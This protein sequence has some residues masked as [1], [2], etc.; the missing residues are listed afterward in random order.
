MISWVSLSASEASPP[1]VEVWHTAT[2]ETP[3]ANYAYAYD[4]SSG[5]A[6]YAGVIAVFI[7]TGRLVL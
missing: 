6:A 4:A 2:C 7:A 3:Q 1:G 5:D